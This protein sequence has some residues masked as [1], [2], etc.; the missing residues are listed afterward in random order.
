MLRHLRR[1]RWGSDANAASLSAAAAPSQV[2]LGGFK[3]AAALCRR[4]AA[5]LRTCVSALVQGDMCARMLACADSVMCLLI[6][7]EKK[8]EEGGPPETRSLSTTV[9]QSS[10]AHIPYSPA[11]TTPPPPPKTPLCAAKQRAAAAVS[12]GTITPPVFNLCTPPPSHPPLLHQS[13]SGYFVSQLCRVIA[14]DNDHGRLFSSLQPGLRMHA[15]LV[16]PYDIQAL[17]H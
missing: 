15:G 14:R 12:K 5:L 7:R 11:L 3:S 9:T 8:K 1:A 17:P 4:F 16:L 10:A 2:V 6:E 13:I